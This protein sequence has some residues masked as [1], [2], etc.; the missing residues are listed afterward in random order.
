MIFITSLIGINMILGR[1]TRRIV[2][3][4]KHGIDRS[5]VDIFIS[6]LGS[7]WTT[8]EWHLFIFKTVKLLDFIN[9]ED[10]CC[11]NSFI[12]M[13][14]CVKAVYNWVNEFKRA[15]V[16]LSD[17]HFLVVTWGEHSRNDWQNP[18]YG[19]RRSVLSKRG[20]MLSNKNQPEIMHYFIVL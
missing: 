10:A 3:C 19:F 6:T 11:A 4:W 9:L 20:T 13:G 15:G 1:C 7:G 5:F 18:R 8:Q 17:G 2:P 14:Y 12:E 16:S